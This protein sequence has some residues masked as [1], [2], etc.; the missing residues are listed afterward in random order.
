MG[1][2]ISP[3]QKHILLDCFILLVAAL[4]L[5]IE[6]DIT[7]L[8]LWKILHS[9]ST[10]EE[11]MNLPGKPGVITYWLDSYSLVIFFFHWYLNKN[12]KWW[13]FWWCWWESSADYLIISLLLRKIPPLAQIP[14]F[15]THFSN[16]FLS[17]QEC[18]WAFDKFIYNSNFLANCWLLPWKGWKGWISFTRMMRG[19]PKVTQSTNDVFTPE[20]SLSNLQVKWKCINIYEALSPALVCWRLKASKSNLVVV[21]VFSPQNF[22]VAPAEHTTSSVSF[23][24]FQWGNLSLLG[25]RKKRTRCDGLVNWPGGKGDCVPRPV[26]NDTG[27]GPPARLIRI[28]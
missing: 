10:R 6:L 17:L 9:F 11:T 21:I 15:Q 16:S 28:K 3:R 25:I 7:N 22:I 1:R 20:S 26:T 24:S 27:P 5:N 23:I 19:L 14:L 4:L 18:R 13:C 2:T 8:E 12:Y